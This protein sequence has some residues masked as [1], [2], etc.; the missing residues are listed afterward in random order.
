MVSQV[1]ADLD[2]DGGSYVAA[3][4]RPS[5]SPIALHL[6]IARAGWKVL[7]GPSGAKMFTLLERRHQTSSRG[8]GYAR[9]TS[10]STSPTPTT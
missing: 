9:L 2:G 6:E 4:G 10:A 8:V 1:R 3:I 5:P 7:N